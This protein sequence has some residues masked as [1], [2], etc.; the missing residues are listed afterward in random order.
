[1][2]ALRCR[3]DYS[4]FKG[5]GGTARHLSGSC[6]ICAHRGTEARCFCVFTPPGQAQLQAVS[7][8][9]PLTFDP[10]ASPPFELARAPRQERGFATC[11][12][13]PHPRGGRRR[14]LMKGLQ[15]VSEQKA[16]IKQRD[17]R[18]PRASASEQSWFCL[19]SPAPPPGHRR[20]AG[21][22][23]DRGRGPARCSAPARAADFQEHTGA[24]CPVVSAGRV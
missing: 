4:R 17:P 7:R 16:T 20:H 9:L 6:G 23:H 11:Q 19:S 10:G 5:A 8:A 14:G 3:E 2:G 13:A 24:S 22:G 12:K 1:M 15:R 21:P 18:P